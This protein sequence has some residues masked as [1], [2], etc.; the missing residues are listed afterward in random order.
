MYPPLAKASTA[1]ARSRRK[2]IISFTDS[3][4]KRDSSAW[5]EEAYQ[6]VFS[7]QRP[8]PRTQAGANCGHVGKHALLRMHHLST[9][10][11]QQ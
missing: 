1:A 11:Q 7:M 8:A 6:H 10:L 2:Y 5:R 4:T 9:G 3:S